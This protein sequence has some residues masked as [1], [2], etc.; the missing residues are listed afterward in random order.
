[1]P[2]QDQVQTLI[3]LGLTLRQAKIY[4]SLVQSGISTIGKISQVSKVPRPD[5]YRIILKLQERGLAEKIIDTPIRFKAVPMK[6]CVHILLNH[7]MNEAIK[8][9]QEALKLLNNFEESGA[10]TI[11]R[12]V[13]PQFVLVPKKVAIKRRRKEIEAAQTSIDILVSFKRLG[14][15]A[16]TCQAVTKDALERGVKIRMITEKPENEN[17]IP[18]NIQDFINHPSFQLRYILNPPLAIVTIYDRKKILVNTSAITGLGESPVFW[19]NNR[20]LL[21]IVNDFYEILWITTI[22]KLT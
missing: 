4:I 12:E 15:T 19:S 13:Y 5:I 9:R 10:K 22:E 8:V 17:E 3:H 16:H 21:A 18:K 7:K 14:P 1:M 11:I 6:E 2:N 20:S